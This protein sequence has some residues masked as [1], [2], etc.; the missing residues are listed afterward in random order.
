MDAIF[1]AETGLVQEK[2]STTAKQILVIAITLV[3][4]YIFGKVMKLS[5]QDANET[6]KLLFLFGGMAIL[7]FSFLNLELCTI[8]FVFVAPLTTLSL[9]GLSFYF[10][11]GDAHL[12]IITIAWGIRL[13]VKSG[14]KIYKSPM[15]RPIFLF[16]FLS[17][18][19]MIKCTDMEVAIREYIQTIEYLVI[20]FYVFSSILNRKNEMDNFIF[21]LALSC[22][23]FSLHGIIQYYEAREV[24]FRVLSTFGHFNAYGTYLA[25][26]VAFFF[27]MA[28]SEPVRWRR[29][30]F[31]TAMGTASMAILFTFSRGAWI[32]VV[33][34]LIFSAWL[35]GMTQFI[36][37]FALI[38]LVVIVMSVILP[39][40]FIFR[41]SSIT[42]IHDM[43][44]QSRLKQYAM[45]VEIITTQPILGV[46][47]SQ[48]SEYAT[49]RGTPS[50]AEIHNVFLYLAAERGIPAM[51]LFTWIIVLFFRTA[52][53]RYQQSLSRKFRGIY[54]ASFAA[55]CSFMIVNFTAFQLVRGL[56]V[57]VGIFFGLT[58]AAARIEDH[59]IEAGEL[60]E[61]EEESDISRS[62]SLIGHL[63]PG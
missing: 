35:R 19:G 40:Q 12:V 38:L 42:E 18:C 43:S 27:N 47:V 56:G 57:F 2:P 51:I 48:L 7:I 20:S 5:F 50:L 32:G 36:K 62:P 25:F 49:S 63:S 30:V 26:M 54:L 31:W 15:D 9:P 3:L 6:L 61:D 28:L 10:T 13:M 14:E 60:E 44:T 23:L 55:I 53:Q 39:E 17:F 41:V 16:L 37:V 22:I 34:A 24:G 8:A 58:M 52:I 59:L 46:G 1:R 11:Y 21:S 29:W 4:I 45:G 33:G